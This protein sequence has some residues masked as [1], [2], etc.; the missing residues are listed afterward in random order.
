MSGNVPPGSG[1]KPGYPSQQQ[2]RMSPSGADGRMMYSPQPSQHSPAAVGSPIGAAGGTARMGP[3]SGGSGTGGGVGWSG[4]SGAAGSGQP[5]RNQTGNF[6]QQPQY[7]NQA[8][9]AAAGVGPHPHLAPGAGSPVPSPSMNRSQTP[10]AAGGAGATAA[11]AASQGSGSGSGGAPTPQK[12][13]LNLSTYCRIGQEAVQEIVARTQE[14]FSYMKS[15]Q[16]PVGSALQDQAIIDKQNRLQ[17]VLR[18]ITVLFKRLYV[19]WN[20]AQEH[21]GAME[22]TSIESLIPLKGDRDVKLELEKK[23]G[24]TYRQALEEHTEL[25]QQLVAK[26]RRLKEI[27]DQMRIMIWEINTMLAMR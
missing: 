23:R 18:G 27:I 19:C 8:S 25:T 14:V 1:M 24:E 3:A 9:P 6:M 17:D 21:A 2:V 7:G 11:T 12:Q 22:Y 15:L 20:K 5:A 16:P 10:A 13:D 4:G 26:N